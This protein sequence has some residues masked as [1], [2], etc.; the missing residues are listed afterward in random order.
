M[1]PLKLNQEND[2]KLATPIIFG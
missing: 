2:T 1:K